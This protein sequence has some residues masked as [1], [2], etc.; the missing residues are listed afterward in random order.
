M[1]KILLALVFSFLI[2]HISFAQDPTPNAGFENWTLV[3]GATQYY[4]PDGWDNLNAATSFIGILTCVQTTD[5]HSGSFAVK[6]ITKEVSTQFGTDTANGIITTGHL[7]LI[8]PYGVT[9]GIPFH[10]RPDSIY[11][12]FKYAPTPGDSTQIEFDLL[13]AN[14]DTLGKALFKSGD[15]ISVYTRFSAPIVYVSSG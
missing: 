8:P 3:N 5:A 13:G 12:W 2:F 14:H 7:I 15:N 6:L 4:V 10:S 1:K 11:G 9:G